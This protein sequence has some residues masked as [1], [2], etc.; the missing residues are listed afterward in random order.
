MATDAMAEYDQIIEKAWKEIRRRAQAG[1]APSV[2]RLEQ[3]ESRDFIWG[4]FRSDIVADGDGTPAM[5][6]E[7]VA[8]GEDLTGCL[9]R[10]LA[11]PRETVQR[12]LKKLIDRGL[13][14]SRDGGKTAIWQWTDRFQAAPGSLP[15]GSW[16]RA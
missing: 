8:A 9:V 1:D 13:L 3:D 12:Q 11:L 5:P 2:A 4:L 14:Q 16:P 7:G 10:R 15:S 6:I